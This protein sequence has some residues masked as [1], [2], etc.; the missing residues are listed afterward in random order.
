M[1]TLT[2]LGVVVAFWL[3]IAASGALPL[4]ILRFADFRYVDEPQEI[5]SRAINATGQDWI[6]AMGFD[7][8]GAICPM[9]VKIALCRHRENH[10]AGAVYFVAGNAITDFVTAFPN[11]VGVTTSSTID[12]PTAPLPPGSV[13]QC[14][15]SLSLEDRWHAHLESVQLLRDHLTATEV[16]MGSVAEE[17]DHYVR[18]QVRHMFTRPWLVLTLPYRYFVTRFR[19]RNVTVA[20]QLER[21]WINTRALSELVHEYRYS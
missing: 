19:Y 17:M 5:I 3:V 6:G 20:T 15:P 9:G 18:R 1:G 4:L 21:G 10:A 11:N 16:S 14:L 13:M 7:P 2:L 12:G 8:E